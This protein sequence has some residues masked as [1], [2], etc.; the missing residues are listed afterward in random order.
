VTSIEILLITLVSELREITDEV[1][2]LEPWPADSP[3]ARLIAGV[4][5]AIAA[6]DNHDQEGQQ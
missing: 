2:G 3:E 5:A 4:R 6:W 1:D